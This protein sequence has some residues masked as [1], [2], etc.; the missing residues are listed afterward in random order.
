[1]TV[2]TGPNDFMAQQKLHELTAAFISEHGDFGIE[3]FEAGSVDFGRLLENVS[4]LPFLTSRRMI[5]VRD[6]NANKTL[7]EKIEQLLDSVSDTTD[8][9][10]VEPKFDKRLALYKTLKKRTE[11]IEFSELDERELSKWIVEY[12]K[13]NGGNIK[14]NDASYLVARV[15]TNQTGIKHELDKLL[16]YDANITRASIE[17]LTEQLP[18]SSM[19]D[20][21]DAAFGGDKQKAMTLYDDQRKQQVEPQAI[22]G[23]IAWQLHIISVVKFNENDS[24]ET[25]ARSA[26]LNP[27]VVR[28]TLNITRKLTEAKAKDLVKRALLLDTRLKSET[29]DADDVVRHFIVTI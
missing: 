19:F 14:P 8:L 3:F 27:F 1:M 10:L 2:I 18:Q 13:K 9:V 12:V 22:M 25:I 20:L 15:G 6:L 28:K 5:I 16:N 24:V 7:S 23:M 26:K 4:S 17:L 29:L 21:L 11:F